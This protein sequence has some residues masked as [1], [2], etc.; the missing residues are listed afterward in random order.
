M[1]KTLERLHPSEY[2]HPFD[3]KALDALEKTKGVSTIVEK[4]YE[5]GLENFLR[6]QF[7]GQSLRLSAN[8]FPTVYDAFET[9]C[10]IMNFTGRPQ[11]YVMRE[12]GLSCTTLGVTN[13]II[14]IGTSCIEQFKEDE[15]LFVLGREIGHIQ[16]QHVK[17][18]EIAEML[19]VVSNAL[20]DLTLGLGGIVASGFQLAMIEWYRATDYTADRAG[21]LACQNMEAAIRVL[22]QEAGLPSSYDPDLMLDDF[23]TQAL[24]FGQVNKSAWMRFS[25][26][27]TQSNGWE[28]ARAQQLYQWTESN[29]YQHVIDRKTSLPE[30]SGVRFCQNCGSK[31]IPPQLFCSNCGGRLT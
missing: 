12:Q 4:L 10:Q 25:K 21:L 27:L 9:A 13:T 5:W 8:N 18:L 17:Y 14:V 2:R 26:Y 20:S 3:T 29:E 16:N 30:S 22:V 11:L 7:L 1:T 31:V 15:L 19:P 23:K 28:V 24:E 6:Q